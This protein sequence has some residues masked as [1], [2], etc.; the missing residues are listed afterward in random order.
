[1]P[2]EYIEKNKSKSRKAF[3]LKQWCRLNGYPGVTRECIIS[4]VSSSDP[5]VAKWGKSAMVRNLA[6]EETDKEFNDE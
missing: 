2:K 5:K 4:A 3:T 6:S 1:M